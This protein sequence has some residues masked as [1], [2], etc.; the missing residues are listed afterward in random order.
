MTKEEA[1]EMITNCVRYHKFWIHVTVYEE[2]EERGGRIQRLGYMF[3][4]DY[5]NETYGDFLRT[6]AGRAYEKGEITNAEL[7]EIS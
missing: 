4:R 7:Y 3:Y 5:G 6:A 1:I 2:D